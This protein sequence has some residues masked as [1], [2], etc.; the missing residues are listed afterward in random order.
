MPRLSITNFVLDALS[1]ERRVVVADWRIHV[2]YLRVAREH[3]LRLPDEAMARTLARK[4]IRADAIAPIRR[5]HGL[6]RVTVP[7]ASTLPAPDEAVIQE[8]NP[9]AVFARFSAVSF[10]GLTDDLPR[11]IHVTYHPDSQARL[12]LGTVPDDWVDVPRAP[13]RTPTSIGNRRVYWTR[14]KS[15]WDFGHMIGQVE[16]TPVYLTDLERTLL[17]CLRWPDRCGGVLT[18]FRAWRRA[19][20][21]LNLDRF[22]EYVDRMDQAILRQ[23]AGFLVEQLGFTH[24]RVDDWMRR[25]VRGSS[26]KLVANRD[27]ASRFSERWN[28]SLN[29]PT[30]VLSELADR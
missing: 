26:A 7:Y 13:A 8:A 1:R 22:V 3:S 17:D 11:E 4:L 19:A 16:G 6:F 2:V 20:E 23:R 12:P 25:A 9:R 27:F 28:L 21:N 18:V 14:T 30:S 10:H 5:I 15:D 24:P 29:V